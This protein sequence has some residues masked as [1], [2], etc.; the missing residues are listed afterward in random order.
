MLN[1]VSE[2]LLIYKT[3]L[4]EVYYNDVMKIY[5]K[6]RTKNVHRYSV[7]KKR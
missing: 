1:S 5:I 4:V 2:M 6:T 7:R 3:I